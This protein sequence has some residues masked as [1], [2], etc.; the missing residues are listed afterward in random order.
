MAR[1]RREKAS[2]VFGK[3]NFLFSEKVSF[4]EAFPEVEQVAVEVNESDAGVGGV[5]RRF[6]ASSLGEYI[7]CSNPLCFNGGFSIGRIIWGMVEKRETSQQG[8]E[9][10]QGYEGSPKGRRKYR[11]CMRFFKW[12]VEIQYKP[13]DDPGPS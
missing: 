6:S 4:A 3:A 13:G 11:D 2:E 9:I 1:D 5:T 8:S 7:D 12:E 10:C